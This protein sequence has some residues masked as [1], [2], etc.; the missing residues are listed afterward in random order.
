MSTIDRREAVRTLLTLVEEELVVCANGLLSRE[1]F[2]ERDRPASFYMIGSMGLASSI[3]LGL[4]LA[5]P[6]R[7]VLVLDG[8]GNLLMGLGTLATI[9]DAAP[10]NLLHVVI[11]DGVHATTGGQRASSVA[12]DLARLAEAAGHRWVR[13]VDDAAA[14]PEALRALL[15][16]E[17]PAFLRVHVGR[18]GHPAPPRVSLAPAEMADR[19]RL[20]ASCG[21]RP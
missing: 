5:R 13:S 14:L 19:F 21:E 3:G 12:V 6:A 9:A 16:A 4:A 17:G 20:A 1:A 8:D 2:A 10:P 18:S 7:R 11:D 15:G